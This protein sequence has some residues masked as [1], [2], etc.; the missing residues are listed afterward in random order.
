MRID[1]PPAAGLRLTR[2]NDDSA[3]IIELD[4]TTLLLDPWLGGDAVLGVRWMSWARLNQPTLPAS[5]LPAADAV[6]VSHPFPDH[7]HP[8]SLRQLPR[9]LP[10]YAPRLVVPFL[11]VLGGFDSVQEVPNA[12][13]GQAP[14]RIGNVDASWCR[15][16]GALDT[17]HNGLV[18]KGVHSGASLLY[19]P[20][21]MLLGD[22]TMAAVER[23]VGGRLEALLCSFG[24]LDLPFW[25]GGV[26][27]LG[28][29]PGLA[30]A[31][32]LNPRHV[33]N[34]HD[35]DKVDGGLVGAVSK[36]ERCA[37]IAGP[38]GQAP[39]PDVLAPPSPVG[40]AWAPQRAI[41]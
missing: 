13:A 18:L 3:W 1:A 28:L 4:G 33:F 24:L 11:K 20:H 32:H 41:A 31:R 39:L 25:L 6:I 36:V 16:A 26:A 23:C 8:S 9:S 37:A 5:A 38:L 12:T 34:T 15:A 35:G 40:A 22:A 10:A 2:I 17:T 29:D 19:C 27:N 21:G 30:L 7:C 14:V